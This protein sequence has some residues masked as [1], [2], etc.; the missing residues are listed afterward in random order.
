MKYGLIHAVALRN[1]L[2][3]I[4]GFELPIHSYIDSK[5]LE[6]ACFSTKNVTDPILRRDVS[7]IQQMLQKGE[8]TKVTHVSSKDQLADA[9]T[10]KGVNPVKLLSVL[11]TGKLSL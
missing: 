4:L 3:E 5:T 11:E 7:R 8:I 9:L 10:K 2:K 6:R 1:M